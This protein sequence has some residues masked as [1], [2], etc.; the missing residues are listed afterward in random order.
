MV[1]PLFLVAAQVMVLGQFDRRHF[2]AWSP[3]HAVLSCS[4]ACAAYEQATTNWLQYPQTES[5][6][7]AIDAVRSGSLV[8]PSGYFYRMAC[9]QSMGWSALPTSVASIVDVVCKAA[10]TSGTFVKVTVCCSPE[11]GPSPSPSPSPSP[12]TPP[13]RPLHSPGDC[14][15]TVVGD[16][17]IV[18]EGRCVVPPPPPPHSIS[19]QHAGQAPWTMIKPAPSLW[20]KKEDICTHI[21]RAHRTLLGRRYHIQP[22][23]S[24]LKRVPG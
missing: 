11:E 24:Q 13:P 2:L 18:V 19:G 12:G 3:S 16:G 23:P 20:S 22:H 5:C 1:S 4:A 7:D 17:G 6:S 9:Q 10:P 8:A 14:P 21:F 15:H